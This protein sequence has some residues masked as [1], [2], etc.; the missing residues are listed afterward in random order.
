MSNSLIS[1]SKVKRYI[2]DYAGANRSHK[3]SR[4][5]QEAI[6]KVEAAARSAAKAI[7]TSAPSKGKTL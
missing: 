7:V 1:T 5:S 2:L 3:F 4:V 6:D